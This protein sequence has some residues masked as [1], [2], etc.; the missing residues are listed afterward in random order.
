MAADPA[1]DQ[2]R[3]T[4]STRRRSR[5]RRCR[6]F[7]VRRWAPPGREW[8]IQEGAKLGHK[9]HHWGPSGQL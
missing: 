2:G 9:N 6:S 1:A 5:H 4:C 8:R 7:G 3:V